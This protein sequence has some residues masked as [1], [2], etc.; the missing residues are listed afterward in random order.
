MCGIGPLAI[1]AYFA[2]ADDPIN[3]AFGH[4]LADFQQVVIEALSAFVF[5]DNG[6]GNG[7]FAYFGHFE[8]TDCDLR[9]G[10]KEALTRETFKRRRT[11]PVAAYVPA[12]F[13][14][15]SRTNLC[16]VDPRKSPG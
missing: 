9:L 3:V 14:S 4:A 1:D 12:G 7:T 10:L 15:F 2:T 16:G 8:Y 11:D 6:L 5:T 13:R